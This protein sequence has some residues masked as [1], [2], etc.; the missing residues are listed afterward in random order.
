MKIVVGGASSVGKSI[1]G[2]LSLGDNDI[3]VVD[4]DA[5][6]LNEIA[7]EYDVQPVLGSVSHPDVQESIGMK[8]MDMLIA[9]TDNDEINMVACQ[10]A[11]T[12]FNVPK[13]IAR[14]DSKYFLNP[15]WN[16]LY[17]KK[18]DTQSFACRFY[19]Q[20]T[21]LLWQFVHICTYILIFCLRLSI[22]SFLMPFFLQSASTV[23]WFA[24]A[25]AESVS[26]D[27]TM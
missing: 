21:K 14:V 3:V 10:V 1:V 16:T 26:P 5:D 6:K 11:Y 20:T 18:S 2:Y 17:N 25:M 19:H 24:L 7:K 27:F 13:K 9:V 12:L 23:V 8:N 15:L 22:E 4:E